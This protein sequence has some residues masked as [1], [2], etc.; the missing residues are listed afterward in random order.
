VISLWNGVGPVCLTPRGLAS[1]QG[2]RFPHCRRIRSC[3]SLQDQ[4]QSHKLDP[5]GASAISDN[6]QLAQQVSDEIRTLS[7]L[8][9]APLLEI[10]RLAS[11]LRW[12]VD[13]FSERSKV[14]VDLDIPTDFHRL[15]D[16][17]ELAIFRIS[18]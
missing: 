2:E 7:H 9:H 16:E 17:T 3:E 15:P 11:A 13:G 12:Y 18:A 6:T 10:A 8:L 5:L 4:S 1:V 14:K